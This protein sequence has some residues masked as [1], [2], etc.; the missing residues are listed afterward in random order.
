MRVVFVH[1]F[2]SPSSAR[3]YQPTTLLRRD[4]PSIKDAKS[5]AKRAVLLIFGQASMYV[6]RR[7]N[8]QGHGGARAVL[9]ISVELDADGLAVHQ[10]RELVRVQVVEDIG[11]GRQDDPAGPV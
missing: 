5:K 4:S 10:A 9:G 8:L 2:T 11:L 1:N 7:T 6:M 3:V